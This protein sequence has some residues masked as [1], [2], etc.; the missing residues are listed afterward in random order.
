[1]SEG[2]K[3]AAMSGAD[4]GLLHNGEATVEAAAVQLPSLVV[5]N[6]S[7]IHAYFNNLYNGH[8]SPLNIATN[9]EGYDDLC[10]SLT[11]IPEKI[12]AI[13]QR[14]FETPKMRYYYAKLYRDQ[15]QAILSKSDT[16]PRLTVSETGLVTGCKHMVERANAYSALDVRAPFRRSSERK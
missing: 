10:G 16:N 7:N 2:E 8:A 15:I 5:D 14:N 1:M 4:F 3:Y 13:V 6:R 11:A 12:G 9:Y